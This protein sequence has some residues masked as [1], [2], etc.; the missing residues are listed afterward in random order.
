[1]SI[2]YVDR[3]SGGVNFIPSVYTQK[4]CHFFRQLGQLSV[5]P[6][7][8]RHSV[9]FRQFRSFS[10]MFRH[11]PVVVGHFPSFRRLPVIP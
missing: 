2:L 5:I 11:F 6:S 9:I 4:F 1:M 8:F 7:F 10:V 3:T